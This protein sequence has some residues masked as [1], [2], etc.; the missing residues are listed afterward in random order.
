VQVQVQELVMVLELELV[1]DQGKGDHF[2]L[3]WL[4]LEP[5]E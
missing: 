3:Q 2:R 1:L 5:G 4:L